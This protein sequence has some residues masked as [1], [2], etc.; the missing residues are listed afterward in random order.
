[1]NGPGK[2]ILKSRD[3]QAGERQ[4]AERDRERLRK[5]AIEDRDNQENAQ[6]HDRGRE[7]D[8]R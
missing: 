1:V 7:R 5:R 8:A 2:P 3:R 6:I 4:R